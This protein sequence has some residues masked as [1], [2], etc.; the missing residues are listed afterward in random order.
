MPNY[1][2][3][4]VPFDADG[5]SVNTVKLNGVIAKMRHEWNSSV[6]ILQCLVHR[7]ELTLKD[8][9]KKDKDHDKFVTLLTE[10]IFTVSTIKAHFKGQGWKHHLK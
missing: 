2:R 3:K 4:V 7:L 5:A 8:T 9:F 1:T 10:Q 6:V